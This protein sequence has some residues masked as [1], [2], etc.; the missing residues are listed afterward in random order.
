M[1]LTPEGKIVAY[2]KKRLKEEGCLVRKMAYEGRRGA[3]D[4]LV[5]VPYPEIWH[6]DAL[7]VSSRCKVLFIEFKKDETTEPE[8]HQ[9]A[10][11]RRMRAAGGDVRV[12][13]STD[14]VDALLE[15]LFPS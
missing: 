4:M 1:A 7:M 15:E 3:P 11:H 5:L 2:A 10:E 13:G 14:Q 12:I 9:L 6:G 8:P